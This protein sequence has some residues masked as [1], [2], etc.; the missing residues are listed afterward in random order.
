M[1]DNT[2]RSYRYEA[3][4]SY[5]HVP[6]DAEIAKE[7]QH[8][9]E[10][11]RIPSAVK[12]QYGRERINRIFRDQEELEVTSDLAKKLADNV[13]DSEYLIAICSPEYLDSQWCMK[14][15]HDFLAT[16]DRDHIICVIAGGEP[17]Y[18]FPQELREE[19]Y[20]TVNGLGEQVVMTREVEPLAI[21]YRGD[22]KKTSKTELPRIAAKIIGCSYDEL[23][24]RR[25]RYVRKR[26]SIIFSAAAAVVTIAVAYLLWSN[27]QIKRNYRQS[28]INESRILARESIQSLRE[29]DRL[30]A[31][32]LALSALPEDDERP[33][34]DDAVYALANASYLYRSP[35]QYLETWRVD[36]DNS[37][38]DYFVSSDGRYLVYLDS[39]GNIVSMDMEN[40]T[41]I[42]NYRI[43][44]AASV[45]DH[46]EE[47]KDHVLVT[48]AGGDIVA[49]DY[50]TGND[51]WKLSSKWR[52]IGTLERSPDGKY[53]ALAEPYAVQIMTSEGKEY[54]SL[55]LPDSIKGYM[56][57]MEWSEDGRYILAEIRYSFEG[58]GL[59]LFDLSTF[60]FQELDVNGYRMDSFGFTRK[61]EIYCVT[62]E[63]DGED[64]IIS[65]EE[66]QLTDRAYTLWV[67]D[68]STLRYSTR[69]LSNAQRPQFF[70]E[71]KDAPG[72]EILLTGGRQIFAF[73]RQGKLCDSYE[74]G[75]VIKSVIYCGNDS[76]EVILENGYDSVVYLDDHRIKGSLFYPEQVDSVTA[77]GHDDNGD[78]MVVE[79]E[80]N[81]Y[82]FRNVYDTSLSY[83]EGEGFDSYTDS[84]LVSEG[85]LSI[86]CYDSIQFYDLIEKKM[87]ARFTATEENS[88]YLPLDSFSETAVYLKL[89]FDTAEMSLCYFDMMDGK[90]LKEND[91]GLSDFYISSH[92]F[93]S[94]EDSGAEAYMELVYM[95]PSYLTVRD[96]V[97]YAH[98]NSEYERIV[99]IDLATEERRELGISLP[100]GY[101]LQDATV[102]EGPSA[103][104]VMD[105]S[106]L[107]TT[108][109]NKD[110]GVI[111]ALIIDTETGEYIIPETDVVD[112]NR[113]YGDAGRVVLSGIY[114]TEIR[115]TSG[116]L[117]YSIPA[118]EKDI[119][120]LCIHED[121]LYIV[122]SD[123][124][125]EICRNGA[126]ERT[127]RLSFTEEMDKDSILRK[128]FRY[129]FHGDRLYLFYNY[130][131]DV[132]ALDT[133]GELPLYC[134][135]SDIIDYL[136]ENGELIM[137]A[138]DISRNDGRS[139]PG[140]YNELEPSEIMERGRLQ[141]YEMERK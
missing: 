105:S 60:R 86:S 76:C 117:I 75:S 107:Y 132:I 85:H 115:D 84:I 111:K 13:R 96:H 65:T 94:R 31:L 127:I 62:H 25:E 87:T 48:Y 41:V 38:T 122:Y 63:N 16:H 52:N 40:R 137:I 101:R 95:D 126:V 47:L 26:N 80:G 10:R 18:V 35:S 81:L 42:K 141:L 37:I 19:R 58:Y 71:C 90:L 12:R 92:Y 79:K 49:S 114:G 32:K 30:Q 44:G 78:H 2:I 6:K 104:T 99:I 103:L 28:Q 36:A 91:T 34:I 98:D 27:A 134:V 55:P 139:Y 118:N 119:M 23:M 128:F 108:M 130:M 125:M 97:L 93:S 51:V 109:Y 54:A 45:P 123:S 7:I 70:V 22:L 64:S 89:D 39:L 88:I 129:E 1:T 136:P 133:D 124:T 53:V 66:I 110:I 67:Y 73:D 140:W 82:F 120:S 68:G 59:G 17:P 72:R 131:L 15:I 46:I 9:L 43:P 106:H 50:I 5:R 11:F 33:V 77:I 57:G 61:G 116:K 29:K 74:L 112:E 102:L 14:E 135:P 113:V 69:I 83:F 3:F 56:T 24:M 100:E 4:I 8:R 138:E 121:R 20:L 21:D